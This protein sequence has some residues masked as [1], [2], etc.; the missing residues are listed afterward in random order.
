[1][2][3]SKKKK[4]LNNKAEHFLLMNYTISPNCNSSD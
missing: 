1:M 2:T 3:Y 4:M